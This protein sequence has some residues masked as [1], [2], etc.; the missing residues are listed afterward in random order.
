MPTVIVP[1]KDP[2][3]GLLS[4]ALNSPGSAIAALVARADAERR[5]R[6]N[7]RLAE[8]LA[9]VP[10]DCFDEIRP[11]LRVEHLDETGTNFRVWINLPGYHRIRN[12]YPKGSAV[13]TYAVFRRSRLLP[14]RWVEAHPG[15][16]PFMTFAEALGAARVS[17]AT[18]GLVRS[19]VR[20]AVKTGVLAMSL[21]GLAV[22]AREAYLYWQSNHQ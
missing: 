8:Q 19:A 7:S 17:G 9:S 4:D 18:P 13:P 22:V 11:Y 3:V 2:I 1:P 15:T 12:G 16:P 10:L 20:L 21:L 5:D 6:F 14:F